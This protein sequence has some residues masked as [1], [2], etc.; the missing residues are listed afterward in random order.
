MPWEHNEEPSLE[1]ILKSI[2]SDHNTLKNIQ[3]SIESSLEN[4]KTFDSINE[5]VNHLFQRDYSSLFEWQ[6]K[7]IKKSSISLKKAE[8][9]F[10]SLFKND[11]VPQPCQNMNIFVP[12]YFKRGCP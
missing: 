6:P 9:R 8:C 5:A 3:T 1:Q 12:E 10:C 11:S 4:G 7:S 2:T